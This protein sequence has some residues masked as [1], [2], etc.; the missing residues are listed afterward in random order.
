VRKNIHIIIISLFFSFLLW[1]S[2][3]LSKDY[4]I[5]VDV[6]LKVINFPDGYS[7][8]TKLPQNISAKIRGNGWK[9]VAVNLGAET[10]Y[11]ISAG[12]DTGRKYI[13]L[14]NSLSENQWLSSDMEVLDLNPDTLSLYI[15][16]VIDKKVKIEPSLNL[17]YK[18]GYSLATD[19]GIYPDSAVVTGPVSY[20]N[21]ISSVPTQE[22]RLLDL[23]S[24][25]TEQ[26]SL[27]DLPGLSYNVNNVTVTLDVQKIVDKNFDNLLVSVIDIPG[28]REVVLL[29]NR[30]SVGVR[31]GINILG[32]LNEEEIKIYVYY[33]DVVLDTLGSV[34]P[35]V[36]IPANTSLIYTKPERLRY[37]IKKFN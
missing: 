25:I 19:V 2:I 30:I 12:N 27:A 1:G 7:S 34:A 35:N 36:E 18:P 15:E 17:N 33:R 6:P 11:V 5:T 29:P 23:D 26:V 24:K 14:Y 22:I 31:G 4:Y 28:D 21:E 9:L 3:S 16:K 10:E 13:N 32:K 20:L 37:I 8:S